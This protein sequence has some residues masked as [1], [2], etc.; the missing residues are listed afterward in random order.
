MRNCLLGT[1]VF[2]IG[3]LVV[4]P[5]MQAQTAP[6]SGA[7]KATP[8]LSGI[9]EGRGG[10]PRAAGNQICGIQALCAAL[11]GLKPE[12]NGETSE[13]PEMLPWAEEQYKAVRRDVTNPTAFSNQ[14]LNPSWGGCLP[15]GPTE[16]SRRRAVEI[17]Q[18]PDMVLLLYDEDHA[19]RRIYLDGKHPADLKPT[20]MGHSIGRYDGETLVIDTTGIND[21]VWVDVQGHPHTDALHVVE[22]V[23]RVNVNTMEIEMTIDDPKT[24]KKPWTRKIVRGLQ[25]PGTPNIWDRAECEELLQLGTHYSA[26]PK[27]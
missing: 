8:D 23:R 16:S 24:Y 12:P 10:L 19:V 2:M 7:A 22:R 5:G 14:E 9:W 26:E 11:Q 17:R 21:K 18:F 25:A 15:E 1:I 4:S 13:V 3:V 27:K 20:W 6:P